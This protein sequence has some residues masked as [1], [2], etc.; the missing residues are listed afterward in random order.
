MF[1]VIVFNSLIAQYRSLK[2]QRNQS[3]CHRRHEIKTRSNCCLSTVCLR[4]FNAARKC[5]SAT[6]KVSLFAICIPDYLSMTH[7]RCCPHERTGSIGQICLVAA[8][9]QSVRFT[10][11]LARSLHAS[12]QDT[13]IYLITLSYMCLSAQVSGRETRVYAGRCH[14]GRS[15]KSWVRDRLLAYWDSNPTG[16]MDV[17]GEC[18]VLSGRRLC[19]E[20]ITRPEESYRLWCVVVCDLETSWMRRPWLSGGLSR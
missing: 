11:S 15:L 17:C 18:C 6:S 1:V 2:N 14:A 4:Q 8:G 13:T 19:D 9:S 12:A 7:Y 10:R 16:G 20:L 5:W 3:L